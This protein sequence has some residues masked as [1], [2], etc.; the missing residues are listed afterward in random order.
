MLVL[1]VGLEAFNLIHRD[2]QV[3]AEDIIRRFHLNPAQH[4]PR[5]FIEAAGHMDDSRLTMFA[6]G[7]L[8]YAI[9]RLIEA[10]GLWRER[11]W[12][13]W[14]TVFSAGIYLPLEVRSL[15]H[16]VTWLKLLMLGGNMLIVIYLGSLLQRRHQLKEQLASA[17]STA[18]PAVKENNKL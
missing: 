1:F 17:S 9:F 16:G 4:Y 2:L 15:T 11:A 10:W 8:A 5:I 7:A 6:I 12:A 14:L 3:L 13:E 18:T